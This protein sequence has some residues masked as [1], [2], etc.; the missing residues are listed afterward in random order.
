MS[1]FQSSPKP[2]LGVDISTSSV[3][4]VEVS[5]P[6]DNPM[7]KAVGIE[8]LEVGCVSDGLIE[9]PDEV[10][11]AIRKL[12]RRMNTKTVRAAIAM[13]T[14][15]VITKR[16]LLPNNLR[17]EEIAVQTE[18]EAGQYIPFANIDEVSLDHAVIGQ[19]E[20]DG[21]SIDVLLV[22]TKR[23]HV[24]D[25]QAVCEVAGLKVVLAD[26][27]QFAIARGI[28]N[29]LRR[30]TVS[31]HNS[32][33]MVMKLGATSSLMMGLKNDAELF[34]R[35]M[36]FGV[37]SLSENLA[38]EYGYSL[39]EAETKRRKNDLP[40]DAVERVIDPYLR[41]LVGDISR[42]INTV[43]KSTNHEK[44]DI[45]LLSGG[46]ALIPGLDSAIRDATGIA[47]QV[48]NPFEG[49]P[50]AKGATVRELLIRAQAPSFVTAM[51]LALRLYSQEH[52]T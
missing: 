18:A 1:L 40:E 14:S 6:E 23:D 34:L 19:N 31:R 52:S 41:K 24:V 50:V 13:P 2:L 10:S 22:A 11:T 7:L 32:V 17:E 16:I 33:V 47:C 51:G 30:G 46:G 26:A 44:P 39:D 9:R 38:R 48:A 12:L 21:E 8:P 29:G 3:K 4:I 35:D 28:Q 25:R 45:I 15:T 49:V 42:H 20:S 43:Q 27:A 37:K 36:S 5:G